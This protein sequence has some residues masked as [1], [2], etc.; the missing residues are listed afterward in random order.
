LKLKKNHFFAFP[1][2][3]RQEFVDK[4]GTDIS[5]QIVLECCCQRSVYFSQSY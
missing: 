3:V 2:V 1:K 4:V 5:A